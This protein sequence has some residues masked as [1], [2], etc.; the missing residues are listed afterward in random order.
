MIEL[1][2]TTGLGSNIVIAAGL[3]IILSYTL[4]REP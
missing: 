1:L 4:R 2:A 3:I